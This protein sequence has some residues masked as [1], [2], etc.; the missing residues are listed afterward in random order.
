MDKLKAFSST[1][2]QRFYKLEQHN[3]TIVLEKS[4]LEVVNEFSFECENQKECVVPFWG[5]KTLPWKITSSLNLENV[6]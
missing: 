6:Q 2:G 3:E 4:P 1:N 5:G